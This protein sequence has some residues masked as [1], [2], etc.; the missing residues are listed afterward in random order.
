[1][2]NKLRLYSGLVLFVFVV[3]HFIN[4]S[5]GLV[6]LA[7]A[8]AGTEWLIDPWRTLPGSIILGAAAVTHV[9]CAVW[10]LWAR[11]SLKLPAWEAM[12]MILGFSAPILLALHVAATRGLSEVSDFDGSYATVLTALW[13]ASPWKGVL[14]AVALLVVWGHACLG[15]HTWLRLKPW[16]LRVQGLMFAVA[17]ALPSAALGGYVAAGNQVLALAQNEVWLDAMTYGAGFEDW[18][19]DYIE[20]IEASVQT[21]VVAILMSILAI[22]AFRSARYRLK[23]R[24]RLN[25]A[26]GDMTVDLVP[27]ATLLESIRTAGIPHASICGGRGRCSTCR[28][29]IGQGLDALA[30]ASET[31]QKALS[32]YST[33]PA[34]RLACQIRPTADIEVSALV[35][36]D[37]TPRKRAATPDFQQGQ[38]LTVAFL[39]VDLRGSTK[40]CEDRLPFDVVFILNQF[41]TEL[42]AALDETDGH[43]AQFNGD[44]LMAIYGLRKGPE[45]GSRRALLG[46]QAMLRRLEALNARLADEL[47]EPLRI[48]IGIHTGQAIVGSM[49]PP[50]TPIVSALGDNVNIAARLESLTKEFGVPLVM[51]NSVARYAGLDG[52]VGEAHTVPVKGRAEPITVH[53]VSTPMELRVDVQAT[54]GSA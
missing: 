19:I 26:P 15:L 29:R 37:I 18:M 27:D 51:S 22:H 3:G 32:R 13:Y 47:A 45:S 49:G 9:G 1:M 10:S 4:H 43:Y 31:E 20:T 24:P 39:F 52:D 16:Y 33:S 6:S 5:L 53:A 41:F 35:P 8:E 14:Q 28:V 50:E 54:D 36:A 46:A 2:R 42:S 40:L 34:V 11:R 44:G 17:I 38:E 48:G 12:Q 23:R 30:P 7:M 21:G 25:Y